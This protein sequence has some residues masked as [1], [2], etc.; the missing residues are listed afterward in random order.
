MP[1]IRDERTFTTKLIRILL[2][3]FL[4]PLPDC[5]VGDFDSPI[6]HHFLDVPVA[7]R[8]RVVEPDT[9]ADDFG[10][11]SMTGI[12]GQG[13]VNRVESVRLFYLW[14][15]LT[16]PGQVKGI[17]RGDSVSQARFINELFGVSA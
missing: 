6:Q 7:Q 11:E 13:I 2:P 8:K 15:K 4:T 1:F 10:R 14:V 17:N 16:I 12:H 9:V 5:F 3:E